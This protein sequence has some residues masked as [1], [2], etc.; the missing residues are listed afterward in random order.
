MTAIKQ[1]IVDREIQKVEAVAGSPIPK[2]TDDALQRRK[3]LKVLA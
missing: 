2:S 3:S 1:E